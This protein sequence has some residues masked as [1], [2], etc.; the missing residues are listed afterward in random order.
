MDQAPFRGAGDR[1]VCSGKSSCGPGWS[2]GEAQRWKNTPL[3]SLY[4][5][6][7]LPPLNGD[8]NM[9]DNNDNNV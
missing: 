7:P 9:N 1:G 6:S 8:N 5:I 3:S 4:R 2:S